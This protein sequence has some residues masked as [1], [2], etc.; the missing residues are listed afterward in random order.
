MLSHRGEERR[1]WRCTLLG[2]DW[3]TR[4][5]YDY[6][7]ACGGARWHVA[8][9]RSALPAEARRILP[10]GSASLSLATLR[11]GFCGAL[12]LLDCEGSELFVDLEGV[13][14]AA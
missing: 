2:C 11:A 3:E 13:T 8:A 9:A 12:G 1:S 7:A 5:A 4:K 10:F 14:D 6:C